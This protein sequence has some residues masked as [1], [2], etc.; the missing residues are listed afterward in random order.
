VLGHGDGKLSGKHG[1][2]LY[3]GYPGTPVEQCQGQGTQTRPDLENMVV[4]VDT[5]RRNYPTN[6]VGVVDEVLAERFARPEINLFR[7]VSYLGPPEQSNGQRAPILPLHVGH[8][9]H[10]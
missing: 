4:P 5:G 9:P 10:P 6:G 2:D 3:C 7:Q 8:A 1:I